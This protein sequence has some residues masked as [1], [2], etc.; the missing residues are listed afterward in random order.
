[1]GDPVTMAVVGG[2]IGAATNRKDPLKGALMGAVGGYAGGSMMGAGGG[3]SGSTSPFSLGSMLNGIGTNFAA[4][5]DP[6]KGAAMN[7][8]AL[9]GSGGGFGGGGYGSVGVPSAGGGY[10]AGGES[11]FGFEPSIS[12]VGQGIWEGVKGINTF[13]NQNPI[14]AQLGLKAASS[15]M[16]EPQ[17][18]Y[19]QPGQISRGQIQPVDYMSLLNPQQQTVMRPQPIS[20]L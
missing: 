3:M 9:A 19:A 16:Q 18:H 8:A 4:G 7:A 6:V 14:T 1:M 12:G 15:L 11:L 20:L 10:G 5:G 13:A 2:S 17:V